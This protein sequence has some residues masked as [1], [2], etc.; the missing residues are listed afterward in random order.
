VFS[1]YAQLS[2]ILAA[3]GQKVVMGEEVG[4]AG[5][6]PA[7]E[8]NFYLEVRVGQDAQDPLA[9]LKPAGR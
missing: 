4:I 8:G 7:G 1:L 3:A 2:S 6:D 5:P 9:W